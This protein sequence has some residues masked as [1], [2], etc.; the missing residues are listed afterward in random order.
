MTAI[1]SPRYVR[2]PFL[3]LPLLFFG[4]S[5]FSQ[6]QM[7]KG[8]VVDANT[9][10]PLSGASIALIKGSQKYTRFTGFGGVYNF[11][12][13]P[14]GKYD[15]VVSFIGYEAYRSEI[16]AYN[17]GSGNIAMTVS[18]LSSGGWTSDIII[19]RSMVLSCRAPI[20]RPVRFL[21]ICSLRI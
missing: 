6:M 2:L 3:L 9:G 18:M 8:K 11:K 17:A 15:L 16:D 19:L 4:F 21:W 7:I 14:A 10:E 20:H 13:I 1:L 5:V 12:N